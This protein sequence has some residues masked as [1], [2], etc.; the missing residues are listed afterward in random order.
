MSSSSPGS[1]RTRPQH[2]R[3]DRHLPEGRVASG[4][5]AGVGDRGV[6][7]ED[8]LDLRRRDVLAAADDPVGAT[9]SDRQAA[10][11]VEAPEVAGP[12]PAVVGERRRRGVGFVEVAAE[13]RRGVHLDLADARGV[14]AGD[15][16]PRPRGV[17]G[18]RC[19]GA[20]PHHR[21]GAP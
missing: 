18:P 13:Q 5:D 20:R 19:L 10:V 8:G 7:A 9:V 3:G 15:P 2:D 1:G 6:V 12:Q 14:R 4:D 16:D 11:G 17:P 21:S